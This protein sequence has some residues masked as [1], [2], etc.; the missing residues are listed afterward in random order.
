[1]KNAKADA[2]AYLLTMLLQRLESK[3][4]GFIEEMIDGVEGDRNSLPDQVEDRPHIE[5]IFDEALTLLKRAN[6][7]FTHS[8]IEK[9][10]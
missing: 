3:Q 10:K 2:C 5:S 8:D 7:P 9:S 6:T 4:S 1:M